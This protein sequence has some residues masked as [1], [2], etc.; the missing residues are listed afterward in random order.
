MTNLLVEAK[1]AA[2][3]DLAAGYGAISAEAADD[4]EARYLAILDIAFGLLPP[5]PPPS[6][7]HRGGWSSAQRAA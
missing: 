1:T 4:I 2:E 6:R 7:R 5:G 3:A